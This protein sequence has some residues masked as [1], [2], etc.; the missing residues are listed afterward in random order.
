M[1]NPLNFW[2]ENFHRWIL[3]RFP[4][5]GFF[6]K[7]SINWWYPVLSPKL[8]ILKLKRE[9]YWIS[10]L[11]LDVSFQDSNLESF[12]IFGNFHRLSWLNP[13]IFWAKGQPTH[14]QHYSFSRRTCLFLSNL[15]F[16]WKSWKS[17]KSWMFQVQMFQ[18]VK[19]LKTPNSFRT[20]FE[21]N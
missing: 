21:I 15:W 18:N 8:C 11:S 6:A 4:V 10:I 1:R 12:E 9:N 3:I 5:S 14:F 19:L 17:W 7:N 16:C 13:S 2:T 20:S